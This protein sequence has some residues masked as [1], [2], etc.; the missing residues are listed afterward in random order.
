MSQLNINPVLGCIRIPE[1]HIDI[2]VGMF[3]ILEEKLPVLIR[4]NPI[5]ARNNV[6][7]KCRHKNKIVNG[8][9]VPCCTQDCTYAVYGLQSGHKISYRQEGKRL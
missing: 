6:T 4:A 8:K 7:C 2:D 5:P 9:S 3:G 1:T